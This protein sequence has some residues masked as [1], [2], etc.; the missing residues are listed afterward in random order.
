MSMNRNRSISHSVSKKYG[1]L[2]LDKKKKRKRN[3]SGLFGDPSSNIN[4]DDI[5]VPSED[6]SITPKR[7]HKHSSKHRI[8]FKDHE[9]TDSGNQ[10]N[11]KHSASVRVKG[12]KRRKSLAL[13]VTSNQLR[14]ERIAATG[15]SMM[16]SRGFLEEQMAADD[17]DDDRKV[18]RKRGTRKRITQDGHFTVIKMSSSKRKAALEGLKEKKKK[19]RRKSYCATEAEVKQMKGLKRSSSVP[20]FTQALRKSIVV[21]DIAKDLRGGKEKPKPENSKPDI[22]SEGNYGRDLLSNVIYQPQD[23]VIVAGTINELITALYK[24]NV[25]DSQFLDMFLCTHKTFVSSKEFLDELIRNYHEPPVDSETETKL[26][27]MK[28]IN[29]LK[30]WLT[31]KFLPL[32]QDVVIGIRTFIQE[33]DQPPLRKVLNKAWDHRFVEKEENS[34]YPPSLFNGNEGVLFFTKIEPLELARQF[35]LYY[36]KLFQAIG[37]EELINYDEHGSI[38]SI[39]ALEVWCSKVR[40]WITCQVLNTENLKRRVEVMAKLIE[41]LWHSIDISNFQG[42]VDMYLGLDHFLVKR[43]KKTWKSLDSKTQ[44]MWDG[45]QPVLDPSG[46]WKNL[47][48]RFVQCQS[49]CTFPIAVISRDLITLGENSNS[50]SNSPDIVNFAKRRLLGN[51]ILN[52]AK[53]QTDFRFYPVPQ[54]Q[55]YIQ[56]LATMSEDRLEAIANAKKNAEQSKKSKNKKNLWKN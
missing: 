38:E 46:S 40:I 45:I 22:F 32:S 51:V 10:S 47:R 2:N 56:N 7:K 53:I 16:I 19:P 3:I 15:G 13:N 25:M 42:A 9:D 1:T 21:S 20:S 6:S 48:K 5:D 52:I 26:I 34:I 23:Q 18:G 39:N 17:S 33:I 50:W 43:L 41:L 55:E 29:V 49:A 35:A 31:M 11:I 24:L 14:N 54:L 37:I 4:L 27:K 8:S 30:R 28:I 36:S 44:E 12:A